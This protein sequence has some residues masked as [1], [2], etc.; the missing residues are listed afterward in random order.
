MK[1]LLR[2]GFLMSVLCAALS[3][4]AAQD[5]CG[6]WEALATP[7]P[8][9][10]EAG[11]LEGIVTIA[12]DDVWAVGNW[13]DEVGGSSLQY[14]L[15]LH[16]DGADWTIVPSPSPSECGTCTS[17]TLLAVDAA[18][19]DDV[20]AGGT[21]KLRGSD[22]FLGFHLLLLHWDGATWTIMDTPRAIPG[23]SGDA[24]RDIEVIAADDIWFVGDWLANDHGQ[25]V[26]TA[27]AMHWD[28]VDFEVVEVPLVNPERGEKSGNDIYAIEALASD[29]IWMV[30]HTSVLA[31]GAADYS[32]IHHWNGAE[33]EHVPGPTPGAWNK[34]DEVVAI[35]PDEV[36]AVGQY[37][38][39]GY[40]SF[41]IRWDGSEWIRDDR[42]LG[43]TFAAE[44]LA[45][46][47]IYTA[48]NAV[49]R[50]DGKQAHL[51]ED[52]SSSSYDSPRLLS[53]DSAGSCETLFGAGFSF[54]G[55]EHVPFTARLEPT[56]ELTLTQTELHRGELAT[57]L[58]RGAAAGERAVFA[59]SFAGVGNGPCPPALG[60]LCIDLLAPVTVMGQ[61][62]ADAAGMASLTLR[63]PPNAPLREVSTQAVIRRGAG[64]ADSVKSNANT[65]RIE[66]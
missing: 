63:V 23:G 5:P 16:W 47:E 66:H 54:R 28:G 36:W 26:H 25:I 7:L 18:G 13:T 43:G 19:P 65:A 10:A 4:T 44:G 51:V 30:G 21:A 32:Q 40:Y 15:T 12:A 29:D 3:S 50:F 8:A 17:V 59:Y 56:R 9:G 27:L 42:I 6:E 31:D 39:A 64:G 46:D 60:G 22:G 2:H 11:R 1:I 58:V 14:S 55:S 49:W 53:L 37:Y 20:W 45:S 61:S 52:W 38:D 57:F 33:W 62:V 34:L 24:I 35:A 41:A 48:S